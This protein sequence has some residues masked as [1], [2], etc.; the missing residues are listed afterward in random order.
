M[1]Y[2]VS[3]PVP[4]GEVMEISD[5]KEH[6]F[7]FVLLNDWSAR[8]LQMFEMKPLGPFHSKGSKAAPATCILSDISYRLRHFYLELDHHS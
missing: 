3:K 7:G 4:F 1:G 8:D 6:I 2:F 5:A